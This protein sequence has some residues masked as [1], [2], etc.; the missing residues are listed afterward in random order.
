MAFNAAL[1]FH[2][3]L[4]GYRRVAAQGLFGGTNFRLDLFDLG[5]GGL[6]DVVGVGIELFGLLIQP[7]P[8]FGLD[9]A[10]TAARARRSSGLSLSVGQAPG[11]ALS[12]PG[13]RKRSSTVA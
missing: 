13:S 11:A 1:L 12:A 7:F 5:I 10:V 6:L 4:Q 8:V 3:V 9:L 2:L